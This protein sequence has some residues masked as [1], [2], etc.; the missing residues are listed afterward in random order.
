MPKHLS[1]DKK[2]EVVTL[3]KAGKSLREIVEL[4]QCSL[5]SV[6]RTL[7]KEKHG[8]GLDRKRGSGRPFGLT[9]PLKNFLVKKIEEDPTKTVRQHTQEASNIFNICLKRRSI[10][11]YINYL[12]FG[13]HSPLRKPLL[14][15]VHIEKRL[16]VCKE[17]IYWTDDRWK[18]I[19][20]SDET[21]INL[22]N[23]DGTLKI[24]RK[25]GE[26]YNPKNVVNTVKYSGGSVMFWGCFSFNG[27]GKLV[28]ID[29]I[30]DRFIYLDILNNNLFES[31]R[32]MGLTEFSFQQDNDP[33]HTSGIVKTFFTRK[34]IFVIDHPPQSPDLNPIENLWAHIKQNLNGKN[35]T[36]RNDLI[37]EVFNIW[38]RIPKSLCEKL[39]LSMKKR[40]R[41]VIIAKGG[42]I[43]Y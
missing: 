27:V 28:V 33:K 19:I 7:K 9:I 13:C 24:W 32:L 38:N 29:G 22:R 21:K 16:T 6:H 17:W 23:S 14:K 25:K 26:R 20:F 1:R 34:N 10:N 31:A 42:H 30:M 39:V 15:S 3:S 35:F 18:Q 37:D 36:N 5:T 43:D 11:N 4:T 2:I 8:I 12:G 41:E 40:A